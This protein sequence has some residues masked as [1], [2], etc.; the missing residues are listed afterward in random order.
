MNKI[1]AKNSSEDSSKDAPSAAELKKQMD[2][3]LEHYLASNPVVKNN[4]Q[5]N[6]LEVRFGTNPK[7]GKFISKVEYDNVIM[8]LLSC[9]FRCDNM[10]G[11]TMLRII[12]EY[13][14]KVTGVVKM[15]N[16]RAEIMGAELVQQYCR[17]NSIKKL[18]DMPVNND[19]KMKFT[20]KTTALSPSDS[21]PIRKIVFD[22]FNFNVSYNMEQDFPIDSKNVADMVRGWTENRK[23]FRLINRV[24]FYKEDTP[25]V[26][27]LSIVRNSRMSGGVMVPTHSME[28]SG[29]FKNPEHCEIEL[30][31]DNAKV[32]VG[33]EYTKENVKALSDELRRIIRV[34]LSGLQETNYPVSYKEQETVLQ[35]YMRLIHGE[36]YEPRRVLSRDFIGPSSCT[37]QL[38]NVMEPDANSTAPNIR[39]NYC[40]TDKADGERKMLYINGVN[41]KMYLINSNMFVQFTGCVA[42]DQSTWDT[43]IDGEH[44]KYNNRREYINTYAA[45]DVY[46]IAGKSTREMDFA[47]YDNEGKEKE[48]KE[49]QYRLPLLHQIVKSFK[50]A[51]I[52]A[53]G[54]SAQTL[55]FKVSV[56]KFYPATNGK[57]IFDACHTVLMDVKDHVYPYETDG[58]IFTPLNTG[59]GG[60]RTGQT[61]ELKKTTWSLSFKWKPPQFNTIDML[62][63]YK[64]DKTGKDEIRTEFEG[65]VNTAERH[66]NHYR[67]LELRCGFDQNIHGYINPFQDLIDDKI[68][69][70]FRGIMD[71][72]ETYKPMPFQPTNPYD[73]QAYIA[74]IR[75]VKDNEQLYMMTEEGERFEENTIVEFSYYPDRERGWRW[76]PL[77]VRHDKTYSLRAGN[78]E[79][80]NAYH[81]ANDNWKSIHHPVTEEMI[82]SGMGIPDADATDDVYYNK[83]K[84]ERISY[85]QS[86]RKFHNMYVKRK[87]IE[88]VTERGDILI[89]YAVGKAGDMSKWKFSGVK[90][91]FGVDVSKDNIYNQKDGAC[92]RYLSERR[93]NSRMFDAIFLPGNSSVNLRN[94]DAFFT[95]KE[96]SIAD[97]I[98]GKGSRDAT[99]HAAA[100]YRHYGIG[101]KGF[102][103]SSCQFALHYFFESGATFNNFLR[104]ISEC[105]QP[106]GYFIATCYDGQTVFNMLRNKKKD[107]GISIYANEGKNKIFEIQK[108][109]SETG[110]ADD[111]TSIGYPINVFQESINN[112][113]VEYLVNYEFFRRSMENYGFQVV[114]DEEA[115]SHGFIRGSGMFDELF[116]AMKQEISKNPASQKW[117]ENADMM[118]EEEKRISFLNRY[119]IFKKAHNVNAEKV[120]KIVEIAEEVETKKIEKEIEKD[121]KSVG[122]NGPL[123]SSKGTVGS[124]GP[125]EKAPA[126]KPRAKK[127]KSAEKVQLS[128]F[129]PI[130]ED[131]EPAPE[132]EEV[133]AGAKDKVQ[134]KDKTKAARCK[135]GTKKYKPMGE[136]CYTDEEIAAYK[137]NK[138]KK[139]TDKK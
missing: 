35:M 20:R 128:D 27:D 44:I 67:V 125:L 25:I 43:L 14:D 107:E 101:E 122:S 102:N 89:D 127:I 49:P 126:K 69:A 29:I 66:D 87:L 60:L 31:V 72:E 53:S 11:A 23:T 45:F 118:T 88:G 1:A 58:L 41:G 18:A 15:S 121:E 46:C 139:T 135:D 113:A 75:L 80:G 73:P 98:F 112:Y 78:K 34:V 123:S 134:D 93:N 32:G 22:D 110:F 70:P 10:E 76:S 81:V 95:D 91:V 129:V 105:T 13:V 130:E 131:V 65:G 124:K 50:M 99:K 63:T 56:K 104:N 8:K 30:E 21:K 28:E 138:T 51:S 12:P 106:G 16:I 85:T 103:V 97:A 62:V 116:R 4:S 77:R 120:A 9:G 86:L 3:M 109:Y 83:S 52:L 24:R 74:N 37:L 61:S 92:A 57:T 55:D 94:G 36:T 48:G 119:F 68:P 17:T 47:P 90:F 137:L 19:Y 6:E 84:D 64:T 59:V 26:V 136:G 33:T 79:Y 71:N 132:K 54:S 5:M 100:V 40:V 117:Y 38:K 42:K 2:T 115:R 133:P 39:N 108:M 111:E 114:T 96:R 82:V 7:K